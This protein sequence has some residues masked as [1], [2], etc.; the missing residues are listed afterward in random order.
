MQ[1]MLK[2]SYVDF[3]QQRPWQPSTNLY[4]S[5]DAYLVC[6]ELSGV[7]AIELEAQSG[8]RPALR[9]VGIRQQPRPC[10][11]QDL[12]THVLEIDEGPFARIIELPGPIAADQ[13]ETQFTKGYVWITIPKK[14]A[15]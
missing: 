8:P 9:M 6:V 1:E 2:R 10:D 5:P 12:S 3:R 15:R 7:D 4:E 14:T 13:V 11:I